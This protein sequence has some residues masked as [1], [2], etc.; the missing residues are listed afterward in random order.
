VSN[1]QFLILDRG[2]YICQGWAN[3]IY[4][5]IVSTRT[6]DEVAELILLVVAWVVA[7]ATIL[8]GIYHGLS[9]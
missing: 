8:A 5:A 2:I 7:I 1:K 4:L 6:L 9:Q 3:N